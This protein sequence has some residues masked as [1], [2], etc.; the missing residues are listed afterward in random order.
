MGHSRN[1]GVSRNTGPSR[2]T[3]SSRNSGSSRNIGFK[4]RL[5]RL[6]IGNWAL[7]WLVGFA[8][9]TIM[10]LGNVGRLRDLLLNSDLEL[11][12]FALLYGGFGLFFGGVVCATA[13]MLLPT[14]E[15]EWNGRGGTRAPLLLPA[16]LYARASSRLARG[17]I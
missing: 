15:D 11:Q 6:V 5:V 14:D 8:F 2:N 16:Y 17:K 1:L 9:S 12:G 7:G 3:G 4:S 13:V 10:L